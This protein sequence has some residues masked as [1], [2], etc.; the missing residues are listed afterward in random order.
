[1]IQPE[2]QI[3]IENLLK[4]VKEMPSDL[5]PELIALLDSDSES[6]KS[7]SRAESVVMDEIAIKAKIADEPDWRKKA[8]LAALLISKSLE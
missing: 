3:E 7:D 5:I 1:M 6:S 2:K 8:T 4:S